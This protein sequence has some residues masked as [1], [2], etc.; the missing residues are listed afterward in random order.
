MRLQKITHREKIT[1]Q[2]EGKLEEM[3]QY[4]VMVS[5]VIDLDDE[6]YDQ[7][8]QFKTFLNR[9]EKHSELKKNLIEKDQNIS[10]LQNSINDK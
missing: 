3:K 1:K 2:I 6:N 10:E 8:P 9:L 5:Q 7:Q 4:Y